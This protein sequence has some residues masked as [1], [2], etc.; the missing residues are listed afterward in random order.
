MASWGE[1]VAASPSL[2][3]DVRA[4]FCQYGPGL[5]YLAT[6]RADGGPRVHPVS[7]VICDDGLYC[8]VVDSPKRRDLDRDGRYAMHAFPAE[9]ADDE[10]YL[11]G[12]AAPVDDHERVDR[13]ARSLRAETRVDWRVYEFTVEVAMVVRRAAS[14]TSAGG[15]RPIA[16]NVWCDPG[17]EKR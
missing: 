2:A 1:F 16:A 15:N 12:R 4:L 10:A 11:S 6:V 5:A 13:L 9:D 8:F 3:A 7:P 17:A 14:P